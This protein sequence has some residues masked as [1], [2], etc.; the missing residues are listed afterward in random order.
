M[1]NPQTINLPSSWATARLCEVA[2]INPKLDKADFADS[3]EVS[4]VPMPAVKAETGEI[5]VTATRQFGEVKK[6]FTTFR[7][8][9]LLFAKIT[10]C[11]ENGKMA[12]VPKVRNGLAFGST[13]F[14]VLRARKGINAHYLYHFVSSQRFRYDAEHNMT[15]AVGQ[16][17]VPT[18]YLADH[19][20]PIPPTDAQ[21]RIVAKLAELFSE[22]DNGLENLRMA[23][24][25]LKIYRQVLIKHAFEGKLTADWRE[26]NKAESDHADVMIGQIKKDREAHYQTKMSLWMVAS[27][28]NGGKPRP[29]KTFCPLANQELDELP[30]L[31]NSWAW[32]KLG[33]M[34]CGV[35]YGTA[36]KSSESGSIPVLR[37]GNIQNGKFDWS[38]LVYTSDEDEI[39]KYMLKEGDVLFNR[40]NSPELVGKTA[41]Y[42]GER[43]ALFAGYLI[44]VNQ[45]PTIVD[46]QYLNLFLNSYIARR[47][48]NRVKTD[49]VNQSNINGDKLSNYPFPYCPLAE[50]HEII[51]ILEQKLSI[52]DELAV[53]IEYGIKKAEA[54]RQSTLKDA[55]SGKL[56]AQDPNDE[57]APAL[58]ERIKAERTAAGNDKVR[59]NRRNAA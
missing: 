2:E 35:E 39:S 4:F 18:T 31:P 14:H 30:E 11:M 7:E 21:N 6:G 59:T 8:G 37:M 22:L 26:R 10:P 50:Q 24:Q 3:L 36:A 28:E 9:D 16:R 19:P 43:P 51:K 56:V 1:K 45:I 25:Q 54:L 32:E 38:D 42:R 58:L 44:R 5:D 48:G 13:E 47:Q 17:R 12:I 40:T 15:G 27:K 52:V 55:F 57:P 23:R 53:S 20:I 49:G 41:I 34:T 29:L 46:S 33:W